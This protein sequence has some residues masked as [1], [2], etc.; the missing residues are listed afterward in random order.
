M[1]NKP[2]VKFS[3]AKNSWSPVC[4]FN[5]SSA[6]ILSLAYQGDKKFQMMTS[7]PLPWNNYIYLLNDGT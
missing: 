6:P 4:T 2:G 1:Q 3:R 7:F 5:Q